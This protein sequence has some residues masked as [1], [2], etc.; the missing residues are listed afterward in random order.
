MTIYPYVL[1]LGVSLALS[2]AAVLQQNPL[3]IGACGLLTCMSLLVLAIEVPTAWRSA[4]KDKWRQHFKRYDI[5]Y[6]AVIAWSLTMLM[7]SLIGTN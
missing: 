7:A 6:F 4:P 3:A 2:Y 1:C 5:A